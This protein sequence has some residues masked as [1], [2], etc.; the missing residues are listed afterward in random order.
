MTMYLLTKS[1]TTTVFRPDRKAL[2]RVA[3]NELNEASNAS[4]V[5]AGSD[6]LVR[7]DQALW[8]FAKPEQN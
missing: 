8:C 5:V 4:V 2:K 3:E 6:V 7:T 1:G